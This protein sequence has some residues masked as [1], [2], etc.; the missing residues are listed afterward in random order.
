MT[1]IAETLSTCRHPYTLKI[2]DPN[3][4]PLRVGAVP[5]K[6]LRGKAALSDFCCMSD[7]HVGCDAEK[8]QRFDSMRQG[9]VGWVL[10]MLIL[11]SV[12]QARALTIVPTFTDG[13]ET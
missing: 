13:S 10:G 11:F 12:G 3:P 5:R 8:Y 9:R 2:R 7:F 6:D 4:S 1:R